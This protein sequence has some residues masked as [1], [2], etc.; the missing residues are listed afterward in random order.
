VTGRARTSIDHRLVAAGLI[1]GPLLLLGGVGLASDPHADPYHGVRL[2]EGLDP[3]A[4][5]AGSERFRELLDEAGGEAAFA[6]DPHTF[7]CIRCHGDEDPDQ[8]AEWRYR[9]QTEACHPRAWPRTVYHRVDADAFV[10]CSNCHVPHVFEANGEECLSCHDDLDTAAGEVTASATFG[11]GLFPHARHADL[12]CAHCHVTRA[13]HAEN[14]LTGVEECLDC[15]HSTDAGAGCGS[16][17]E[18]GSA[19]EPRAV[20][21]TVRA[22][23]VP[24]E[25]RVDFDHARHDE[26]ACERC[27][28]S[29]SDVREVVACLGCH[30]EHHR[31]DRDCLTCHEPPAEE[32]HDLAIHYESCLDADC[33]G[34]TGY[35]ADVRPRNVCLVCHS[36]LVEHHP[37]EDCA[38]CHLIPEVHAA[39]PVIPPPDAPP[40]PGDEPLVD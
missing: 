31:P 19:I 37:G 29:P 16:C 8:A 32:V 35:T 7:R 33:H 10:V 22:V 5:T 40:T 24:H 4:R 11:G 21:L 39:R 9:C 1:A 2:E 36:E 20:S 6:D 15:H 34:D 18:G 38:G 30:E 12:D 13:R 14:V 26:F 17:H 27:H 3:E 23:S 25:R 28:T